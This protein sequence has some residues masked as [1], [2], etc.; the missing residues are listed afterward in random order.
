LNALAL[1]KNFNNVEKDREPA[2][3]EE[4]CEQLQIGEK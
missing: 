4:N 2:G 3:S 1:Y